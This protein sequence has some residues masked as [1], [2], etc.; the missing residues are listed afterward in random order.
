MRTATR[1][2]LVIIDELGRGT[3]TTD[4]FGLA[5]S[6]SEHLVREIGKL[7]SGLTRSSLMGD[8][9]CFTLFATH[10]HELTTLSET[11]TVVKNLHVA[12]HL[13]HTASAV[14]VTLLYKV[15]EGSSNKS[16]GIHVAEMARFPASVVAMAKRKLEELE[17]DPSHAANSESEQQMARRSRLVLAKIGALSHNTYDSKEDLLCKF[18]DCMAATPDLVT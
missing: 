15:V 7:E 18:Q 4:G 11:E 6:I 9:G 10:F 17:D 12:A 13:D 14:G 1:D 5:Y 3:S 8:I 2:S 16:F